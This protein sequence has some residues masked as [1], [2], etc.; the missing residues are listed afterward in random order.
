MVR[1]SWCGDNNN[2]PVL[3]HHYQSPGSGRASLHH[4]PLLLRLL[5]V[6]LLRRRRQVAQLQRGI[7]V[8]CQFVCFVF[9]HSWYL[10]SMLAVQVSIGCQKF[11]N[12]FEIDGLM[13]C[14]DL[15]W[16]RLYLV[17]GQ[18]GYVDLLFHYSII[19]QPRGDTGLRFISWCIHTNC[20]HVHHSNHLL[21]PPSMLLALLCGHHTLY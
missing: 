17:F 4:P 18:C 13:C 1:I 19:K 11:W 6:E 12:S 10:Y 3:H 14:E 2:N 5:P 16:I 8:F 21:W 15:V 7:F 20:H 9:L